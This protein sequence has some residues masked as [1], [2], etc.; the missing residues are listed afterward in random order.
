MSSNPK[1]LSKTEIKDLQNPEENNVYFV[2][3]DEG[4]VH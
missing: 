4:D 1:Y 2:I 3:D